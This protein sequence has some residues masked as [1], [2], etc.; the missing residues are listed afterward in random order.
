[1]KTRFDQ[2]MAWIVAV[3]F[4]GMVGTFGYI[5]IKTLAEKII[6]DQRA[7]V[8]AALKMGGGEHAADGHGDDSHSDDAHHGNEHEKDA[9]ADDAHGNDP[10]AAAASHGDEP[11]KGHDEAHADAGHGA[12]AHEPSA[13]NEDGHAQEHAP[14]ADHH[15]GTATA[16]DAHAEP[17]SKDHHAAEADY[18]ETPSKAHEVKKGV[19]CDAGELQSPIDLISPLSTRNLR[20]L[21]VKYGPSRM[22]IHSSGKSKYF[23]VESKETISYESEPYKLFKIVYKSPSEHMIEG[24]QYDG[25]LQFF[26]KVESGKRLLN[27]SVF[28][29]GGTHT[30]WLDKLLA[31]TDESA[32]GEVSF[33]LT[34]LL[35]GDRTYM[36]YEGS[37][38]ET[39]CTEGVNWIVLKKPLLASPENVSRLKSLVGMPSRPLQAANG[40]KVRISAR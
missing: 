31:T 38:T 10:H 11:A 15:G 36:Q 22:K 32:D 6:K 14:A 28:V 1:L 24:M 34:A 8:M 9:H 26:H 27:I 17:Q 7:T 13:H 18:H 2:T 12:E 16:R 4:A 29:K 33:D 23:E 21:L 30:E 40:R 3:F 5:G 35:P 37:L 25:E 19:A 39:P 20:P